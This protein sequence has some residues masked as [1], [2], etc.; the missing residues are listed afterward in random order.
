MIFIVHFQSIRT[1]PMNLIL[2]HE[3]PCFPV[4]VCLKLQSLRKEG[5]IADVERICDSLCASI[6]QTSTLLMR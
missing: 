6:H 1:C 2:K 3:G 4:L 5:Q